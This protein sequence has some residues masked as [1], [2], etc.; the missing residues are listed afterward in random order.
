MFIPNYALVTGL[1]IIRP[2][3]LTRQSIMASESKD[4]DK[5]REV[6][7]K[8]TPRKRPKRVLE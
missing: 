1:R 8:S 7:V 4:Q 3:L 6:A 5:P 2:R